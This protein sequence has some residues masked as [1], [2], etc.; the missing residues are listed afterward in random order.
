MNKHQDLASV[1]P[2]RLMG[3]QSASLCTVEILKYIKSFDGTDKVCGRG[4]GFHYRD[5]AG[6]VWL[7]TNWHVLTGRRPDDPSVLIGDATASPFSISVTY[8]SKKAGNFLPPLT[9]PLYDIDQQ[10]IWY[11]YDRE[12]GVDLAAIPITL[13]E[14]AICPCI[15]DFAKRDSGVFVPG[16]DLTIVGMVFP[17]SA[18]T[19]Y[20]IWKSARVASEPAYLVMNIPQVLIDSVGVPGM[21]GSPVYRISRGTSLPLLSSKEN[22]DH[23]DSGKSALNLIASLDPSKMEEVNILNFVGVYAGSTGKQ[24]LEKLSLGR[25]FIASLVDLLIEKKCHGVNP[26]PPEVYEQSDA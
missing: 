16:L 9:L 18:E 10:P 3:P 17:H 14:E 12:K 25:M 15:Q 23:L 26:F 8:Q 22:S 21:S 11:E 5:L 1:P 2:V 24:E 6:N 19:P 7:V 4:T 13:P 20:P